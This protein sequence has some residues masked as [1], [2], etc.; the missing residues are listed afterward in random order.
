[1]KK[2]IIFSINKTVM[3]WKEEDGKLVKE[4]TFADFNA[5]LKFI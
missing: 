3:D 1:V 2:A 4:F 5:A